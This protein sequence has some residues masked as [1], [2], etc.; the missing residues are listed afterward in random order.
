MKPLTLHDLELQ[1]EIA[2]ANRRKHFLILGAAILAF[3][4]A[5]LCGC[6]TANG[7]GKP[8]ITLTPASLE[9]KAEAITEIAATAV[10]RNNPKLL[11]EFVKARDDA[12][13]VAENS[14][15]GLPDLMEIVNRFPADQLQG[16]DNALYIRAGILFFK[17]EIGE[18]AVNNPAEVQ[19]A[20]RGMWHA[21]DRVTAQAK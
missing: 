14:E 9:S 6:S 19:A 21:L 2:T 15:F 13:V 3:A 12:K 18:V 20:A 8:L 1:Q 7:E 5:I 17:D 4:L 10:L 16:G 11:D